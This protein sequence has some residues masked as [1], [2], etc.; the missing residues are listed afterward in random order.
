[1][2]TGNQQLQKDK[3]AQIQKGVTT[4]TQVEAMFGPA[5][6]VQMMGDGRRTMVYTGIHQDINDSGEL[7]RAVPF[8]GLLI[9]ASHSSTR[10]ITRLQ[11][12][13][14]KEEVVEDYEFSDNT[15]D[16][17]GTSSA[18]GTHV[19]ETTTSNK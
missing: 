14:N 11:I 6:H 4:R 16:S 1:V 2:N 8:G 15:T 13:L 10:R 19:D 18:F 5:N 12:M 17:H 3:V 9:P 7:V